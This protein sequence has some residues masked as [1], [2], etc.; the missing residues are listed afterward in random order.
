MLILFL[1]PPRDNVNNV[2]YL[3]RLYLLYI[4]H[5]YVKYIHQHDM[6][7]FPKRQAETRDYNRDGERRDVCMEYKVHRYNA[8]SFFIFSRVVIFKE[9]HISPRINSSSKEDRHLTCDASIVYPSFFRAHRSRYL[10]PLYFQDGARARRDEDRWIGKSKARDSLAG[11][12]LRVV[13]SFCSS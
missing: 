3:R 9:D 13:N 1:F 11:G 12:K 6:Y 5:I 10:V 2:T 4:A 7:V 8:I